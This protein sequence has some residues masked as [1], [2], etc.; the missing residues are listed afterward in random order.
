[1]SLHAPIL[2]NLLTHPR[3]ICVTDDQGNH[4][5]LKVFGAAMHLAKL[6][7][8]ATQKPAV[9]LMLPTSASFPMALLGAWQAGKTAVPINYLLE[10]KALHHVILDSGIDT[11]LTVGKLLEHIGGE[12]AIPP[13]IRII[14]LDELKFGPVPP[15][16]FFAKPKDD[17]LAVILYTSGTSGLPKGVMLTHKNLESNARAAVLHAK[18]HSANSFLG[19]LPNFHAFG[20]TILCLVPLLLGARAVYTARFVPRRLVD[21]MEKERPDVFIAVPSMYAALLGVKN[22]SPEQAKSLRFVISGAEPLPDAITTEFKRIYGKDILEGYGLT[23]TSPAT[24]WS[25]PWATKRH[26][27]GKALPGVRTFIVDEKKNILP[28]DT[29]GEIWLAGPNL[30]AGYW[31]RP[32]LTEEAVAYLELPGEETPLR[33]LKTGDIGRVDAEG[34]L[35]ITGRKKEMLIIA[36]ENVFPREIEEVLTHHPAVHAA[37][38]V[39][40]ADGMRGEVAV[41]FVELN[42]GASVEGSELRAHCAR[43][44][45]AFKVPREIRMMAALPRN[46]TGKIIRRELA[47]LVKAEK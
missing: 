32:D 28:P 30:M 17:D 41:A 14:K 42:E 16:R 44:L 27:V 15:L 25:T 34:F 47:E 46:P 33:C 24:H 29:D 36:G 5:S 43:E 18:L 20:I 11:L 10:Q 37:A 45:P 22:A 31:K 26:S 9:G 38:V 40:K 8:H 21:L 19:I 3:R 39:G 23:E 6:I 35:F 2:W 12:A 4:S 7:G 13:G 1:M